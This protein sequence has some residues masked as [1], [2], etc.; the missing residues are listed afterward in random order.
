MTSLP[1]DW[2]WSSHRAA[3]GLSNPASFHSPAEIWNL[4]DSQPRVAMHAYERFVKEALLETRPVS[5]T[6]VRDPR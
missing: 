1:E 6:G 2:Q 5:D 3:V 4:F